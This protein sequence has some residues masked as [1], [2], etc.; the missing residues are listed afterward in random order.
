MP[1]DSTHPGG[2]HADSPAIA[3]IDRVALILLIIGGLNWGLVGAVN[4]D[5]VASLFGPG[6]AV[7]RIIYLLVGLAAL[8]GIYLMTRLGSRRL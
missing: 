4:V 7:S 8:Y 6:S 2:V 5:L 3:I 1:I